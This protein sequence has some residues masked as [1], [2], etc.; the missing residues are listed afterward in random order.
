[1]LLASSALGLN[2]AAAAPPVDPLVGLTVIAGWYQFINADAGNENADYAG[3][4]VSGVVTKGYQSANP[5]SP[6]V[7]STD[8]YYGNAQDSG[9]SESFHVPTMGVQNGSLELGPLTTTFS[10][11][12][13]TAQTISIDYLLFDMKRANTGIV[14]LVD[15]SYKIEAG[16]T[17]PVVTGITPVATGHDY[18]D[19][20]YGLSALSLNIGETVE[21]FVTS[22]ITGARMDNIG[23][24]SLT[25]IPEPGSLVALGCFLGSGLLIRRNRRTIA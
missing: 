22:S 4:L 25:P 15:I 3:G 21:F 18:S 19:F 20:G 23:F 7:G 13:I 24:A 6:L 17:I 5:V 9:Y 12:N 10:L 14:P 2:H 11:T 8:T 1:M 16:S